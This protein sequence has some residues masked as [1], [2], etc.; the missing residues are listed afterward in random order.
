MMPHKR[1]SRAR[2]FLGFKVAPS[3]RRAHLA[4]NIRMLQVGLI[5]TMRSGGDRSAL[6]RLQASGTSSDSTPPPLRINATTQQQQRTLKR[7][8]L[9]EPLGQTCRDRCTL[10]SLLTVG[11]ALGRWGRSVSA[12][13][14]EMQ[15]ILQEDQVRSKGL[16]RR[17]PRPSYHPALA[18]WWKTLRAHETRSCM[19]TGVSL[20]LHSHITTRAQHLTARILSHLI[21][22]FLF[23]QHTR[24]LR[25]FVQQKHAFCAGECREN[26]A[27]TLQ[28]V[29]KKVIS[30]CQVP[31][32]VEL[33]HVGIKLCCGGCASK[34][35]VAGAYVATPHVIDAVCCRCVGW[36]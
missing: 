25:K 9:D 1:D 5:P 24:N 11:L 30:E 27:G 19:H 28:A 4:V 14:L 7:T 20:V 16:Q 36:S 15:R 26:A 33:A 29:G 23:D 2:V 35:V 8:T 6:N 10:K 12:K 13:G 22:S 34:R 32:Y 3:N 18:S 31:G 21:F 17:H